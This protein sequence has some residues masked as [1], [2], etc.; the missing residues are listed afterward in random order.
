MSTTKLNK[1]TL[2]ILKNFSTI[3]QS[4]VFKPGSDI[5]TLSISKKV[6]ARATIEQQFDTTFAIYELNKF[7][8][9][10]SLFVDPTI[11]VD[12]TF[13][14]ITDGKRSLKYITAP[15]SNV[16]S[17]QGD[18]QTEL[19]SVDIEFKLPER[20]LK[21]A[22]KAAS[23]LG[24]PDLV[25]EGNGNKV[26]ISTQ[27]IEVPTH[28]SYSEDVGEF[29]GDAAFKFIVKVE[30]M[31]LLPDDYLVRLCFKKIIQFVGANVTYVIAC[32]ASST[33]SK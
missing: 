15:P 22:L 26:T 4:I 10:M 1:R 25:I 31:K 17:P 28:E 14:H 32:E 11:R 19:P 3:N 12:N 21:D 20:M 23:V 33:V 9:A 27:N 16:V 7:F 13:V 2:D 6:L 30:N 24:Q 5:A 8:G 29:V 18:A